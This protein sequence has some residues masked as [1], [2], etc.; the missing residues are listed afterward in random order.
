MIDENEDY[1]TKPKLKITVNKFR[2]YNDRNRV[3]AK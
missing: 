3:T 1:V 2:K